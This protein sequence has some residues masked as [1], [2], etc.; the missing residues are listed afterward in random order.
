MRSQ[1]IAFPSFLFRDD[2]AVYLYLISFFDISL[3]HLICIP[4]STARVTHERHNRMY[5]SMFTPEIMSLA[6]PIKARGTSDV[7]TCH[8]VGFNR[9]PE[10]P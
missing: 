9:S 3:V 4:G 2:P 6:Q 7:C 10:V 8:G 5:C 1:I